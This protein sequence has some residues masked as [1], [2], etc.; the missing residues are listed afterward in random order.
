CIGACGT[1]SYPYFLTGLVNVTLIASNCGGS[2]TAVRV[3]TVFN[4]RRPVTGFIADNTNPTTN[5][6]VFFSTQVAQ[7]VDDYKWTITPS[8]G[9]IGTALFINGTTA[10][11][12]NP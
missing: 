5:D 9:T 4:P 10:L 2:D 1:V 6:V 8:S 11:N 3:L 7:C 12:Q